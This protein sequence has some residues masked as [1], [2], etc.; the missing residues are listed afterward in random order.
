MRMDLN[1]PFAKDRSRTE[2]TVSIATP[3]RSVLDTTS[4]PVEKPV[5]LVVDDEEGPRASLKVVFKN[6]FE[7]L[8]ASSGFEAL[9]I[10]KDRRIDVAILDILMHGMSGVDLLR[11]LKRLDEDVEVI[12]L[13]AYET[14]E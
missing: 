6:D 3:F 4:K 9:T 7:V 11:E 5:L 2:I 1:V 13:T 10:A 12:M 14:L 8:L